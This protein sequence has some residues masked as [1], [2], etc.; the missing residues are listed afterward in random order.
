MSR[1]HPRLPVEEV[2]KGCLEGRKDMQTRLFQMYYPVFLAVIG[3]YV[4]DDDEKKDLLQQVFIAIFNK[5]GQLK[6]AERFEAWAR[7]MVVNTCIDYIRRQKRLPT[8]QQVEEVPWAGAQEEEEVEDESVIYK[9]TM[10]DVKE[11]LHELSEGY[12][13]IFMMYALDNYS[14]KEIAETLG[15][16]ESTSKSQYLRAKAAIKK[17]ILKRL[18]NAG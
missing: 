9:V 12:R 3:R 18:T 14:H 13:N 7:R 2:V 4:K 16:T 17:I 10:E 1:I 5:I 6:E 15:I 8:M 11:A